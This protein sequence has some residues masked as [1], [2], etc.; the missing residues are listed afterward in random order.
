AIVLH[1]LEDLPTKEIAD[2][3]Q[4]AEGTVRAL[5]TQGRERLAQRLQ[6]TGWTES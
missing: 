6:A 2:V 3:L 4:I 5:L 1:Y